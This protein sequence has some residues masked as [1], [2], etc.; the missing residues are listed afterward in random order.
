MKTYFDCQCHKYTTGAYL[1]SCVSCLYQDSF[2]FSG[3]LMLLLSS[4]LYYDYVSGLFLASFPLKLCVHLSS[5][6]W[7][8]HSP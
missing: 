2:P 4:H 7:M 5:P 6:M 8:L 1:V 3:I